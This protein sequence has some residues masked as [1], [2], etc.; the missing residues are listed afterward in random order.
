MI[1]LVLPTATSPQPTLAGSTRSVGAPAAITTGQP[2]T[3]R[4]AP[5]QAI[6]TITLT[7]VILITYLTRRA[8]LTGATTPSAMVATRRTAVG[9]R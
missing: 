3:S 5:A 4:G 9:G 8:R 1:L 2:A 6:A 7:A